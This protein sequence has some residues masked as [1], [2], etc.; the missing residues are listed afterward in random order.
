MLVVFFVSSNG[1]GNPIVFKDLDDDDIIEIEKASSIEFKPGDKKLIK[2]VASYVKEKVDGNGKNKG[3]DYFIKCDAKEKSIEDIAKRYPLLHILLSNAKRNA[4]RPKNGY[5]FDP[6]SKLFA[7]NFRM[8]AGRLAYETLQV[9]IPI[10]MPTLVSTNRYINA[11]N[12]HITEGVLRAEELRLY[13]DER[14]LERVVCLS[15]D[16]TRVCGRVQY[17]TK[18]NQ[19][20]GFVLPLSKSNGLPIPLAYPACS[21]EQ[22]FNHFSDG[23]PVATFMNVIMAQPIANVPAFCLIIFGSDNTY[24]TLNVI[25]RWK[26]IVNELKKVGINVL[27]ISTDSDSKYN[28]AMRELS[29]LGKKSKYKWLS[30]GENIQWPFFIQD[31]THLGTKLRNLLLSTIYIARQLPFGNHFIRLSHLYEL[32]AKLPKDKHQ[33]TASTLSPVDRQNFKSVRRICDTN[34][35]TLLRDHIKH[36][37]GTV[38]YLQMIRD[39]L[40]SLMDPKLSPLQRIRKIWYPLFLIRIWRKFIKSSKKYTC[41]DNFMSSNCYS[42]VELNAQAIVKCVLY[43]KQINKSEYFMPWLF[44]SQPCESI[45]RQFRSFTTTY[46]TVINA[47]L[48]ESINRI[49]KIQFQNDIEYVTSSDFIYP[50]T[51]PAFPPQN[52]FTLPTHEQIFNEIEF[53][54]KL[55]IVT[56]TKHGLIKKMEKISVYSSDIQPFKPKSKTKLR[57]PNIAQQQAKINLYEFKKKDLKNIQLKNYA[58]N[59]LPDKITNTSPYV[60]I[61]TNTIKQLVVKKTSLCWLLGKESIKMSNDRLVRVQ[62]SLT[63]AK[64]SK[65]KKKTFKPNKF[66]VCAVPHPLNTLQKKIIY[67]QN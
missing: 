47:A 49:S 38:Q 6:K 39:I 65:Q 15:E 17:D 62:Y 37:E 27:T 24:T 22:I 67:K 28:A 29:E 32:I 58:R 46:S 7:A 26:Y 53:C 51:K 18:S 16:A 41:K 8:K 48:K 4:D 63:N 11:S 21:A 43:L 64:K 52:Q 50:R 19:L 54:H 61:K 5:R 44:D 3:L 55:A 45:F 35:T 14:N 59:I 23:S 2:A 20:I 56:A 12:C 40:D 60:V 31:S 10:A 33:L 25:Q 42:C 30:S 1:Y 13:L 34:V 36:S 66:G 9:N 57:A